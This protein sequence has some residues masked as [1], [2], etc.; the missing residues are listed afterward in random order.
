M[1]TVA[2]A[3]PYLIAATLVAV[4]ATLFAGLFTMARG[5]DFNARWGNRLMRLRV[6]LQGLAVA[7]FLLYILLTRVL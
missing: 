1:Q 4:A 5:G 2:A 7:L 6:G 3:L